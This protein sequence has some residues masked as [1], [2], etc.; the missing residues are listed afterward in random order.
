[1]VCIDGDADPCASIDDVTL[2]MDRGGE[3]IELV[4]AFSFQH[5]VETHVKLYGRPRA[6]IVRFVLPRSHLHA[7]EAVRMVCGKGGLHQGWCAALP[8][9]ML[10]VVLAT[11]VLNRKN[12][13]PSS[14][15]SSPTWHFWAS[16]LP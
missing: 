15:L 14:N 1:M 12:P 5:F 6:P 11:L 13:W 7:V 9:A 16:S 2:A 4:T 10:T 8:I 3:V